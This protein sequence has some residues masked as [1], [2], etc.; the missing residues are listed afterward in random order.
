TDSFPHGFLWGSATSN[1]QIEGAWNEDGK[2]ESNWDRFCHTPEKIFEGH[3]GDV[4]CDHYHRWRDDLDLMASLGLQSYRFSVSWPRVLPSGTGTVNP[5]GLDFYERIVDG[6]LERGIEPCCTLFH[7]DLPQALED[8][9][10]WTNR[11]TAKAMGDFAYHLARRMGD[12]VQRWMPINEGPCIADNAYGRGAFAPGIK[13]GP[14]LVRQTR[15]T[16]LLAHAHASQALRETL[17]RDKIRV[18]FVHNPSPFLPA[19]SDPADI[20]GARDRFLKG[21]AWWLDP[22]WKGAYPREEWDS[23]GADAPDVLDG[24]LALMGDAPDFLGLNLYYAERFSASQEPSVWKRPEALR[25][26]FDWVVEPDILYWIP[27]WC[28]EEW[29]P[30]FMM[31]TENGCAWEEGGLEDHHRLA[32]YREHLRSLAQSIQDGARVTGYFAWSLL[33]NFEWTSGYSKRFG[34]VHVDFQTQER[35]PKASAKWYAQV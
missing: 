29:K 7:W 12:R 24:D 34:L 14:K 9:G 3:T 31:I 16:V 19:T 22:L 1:F 18:G 8:K 13:G 10:G 23:L 28:Q 6:C 2:G 26:D 21:A 33:D 5:K 32:F 17:G 15:H 11:D 20:A 30:E 27:L 35:T 25:T 4:A